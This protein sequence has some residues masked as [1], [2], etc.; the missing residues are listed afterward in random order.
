MLVCLPAQV[1]FDLKSP[2]VLLGRDNVAKVADVGLAKILQKDYVS[3]LQSCGTFAWS[4][5]A[6]D[7]PYFLIFE[8][9][10]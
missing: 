6:S 9:C 10:R 5:R 3:S 2:N 7:A 1:H 8:R 4:V